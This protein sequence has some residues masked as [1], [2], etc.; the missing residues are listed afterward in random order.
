MVGYTGYYRE[1]WNG[2]SAF[3][4][5]MGSL[6]LIGQ[7]AGAGLQAVGTFYSLKAEQNR[8]KSQALS[9]EFEQTTSAINADRAEVEAQSILDA[10]D[11]EFAAVTMRHGQDRAAR[12]VS[13]AARGI[14][15][16]VGSA[17]EVA[18]SER[19]SQEIDALTIRANTVR[20]AGAARSRGVDL[21]IRG[22]FAGLNART[23]R[24]SAGT[25]SPALGF[26]TSLVSSGGQIGA[27]WLATERGNRFIRG[28]Y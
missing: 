8:A 22:D 19:I 23:L 28:R 12:R 9:S 7:M 1:T 25:I 21:S 26:H 24:A 6:A 2:K 17:A 20:S 4:N 3:Y 16:G 10:G 18:T 27:Q 11:R 13:T 14:V 5:Q 15:A